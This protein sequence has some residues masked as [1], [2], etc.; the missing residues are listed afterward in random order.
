[1]IWL[2][3]LALSSL[4]IFG[5]MA[6][7]R[8]LILLVGITIGLW[9][10][11]TPAPLTLAP[12]FTDHMVLQQTETVPVWGTAEP[13]ATVSI[14]G[15]WGKSVE[16][17]TDAQGKWI[18]MLETP[19]FG[20]P[21]EL[22]IE[23]AQQQ[24]LLKDVMIGEVWLASGQ[25]NMQWTLGNRINN[26]EEEI[27]NAN[28][29]AI[30]MFSVPRDLSGTKIEN[31]QWQVA[32]SESIKTFSAVGYF[33]ARE[34]HQAL[35]VPVGIIN[36]SWGGTRVEAWMRLEELAKHQMTREAVEELLALGGYEKLKSVNL[37]YN[38]SIKNRN[39]A[40]LGKAAVLLPQ[41]NDTLGFQNLDLKDN[42]FAQVDLNTE[43]WTGIHLKNAID[44]TSG[45]MIL[46]F[47]SL[48]NNN[49]WGDDG[50]VWYRKKFEFSPQNSA[51]YELVYEGGVDDWNQTFLNGVLIGQ[52][53]NCCSEVRYS[54]PQNLL[55]EGENTLA[56]RVIDTGGGGGFRGNIYLENNGQQNVI[57]EGIWHFKQQAFHING[58]LYQHTYTNAELLQNE[59]FLDKNL[60]YGITLN[61]PNAFGI[62]NEKMILPIVPYAIKGALW[63]QGESNVNNYQDYQELFSSMIEDWR[64]QWNGLAFPFYYVQIA[65]YKYTPEQSSQ[66]LRDAQRKSLEVAK[67]GMVVTLDIGEEEDIHPA[68]KQD[69]GARLARFALHHDYDQQALVPSGPLYKKHEVSSSGVRVYFD[70]TENGLL[71]K[72][73]LNGFEIGDAEGNFYPAK[74][75]IEQQ[76][77]VLSNAKVK[78]PK[79]V[80]Y[81]WK[82]YFE[83]SLFN[84]EGLPASSFNTY[85]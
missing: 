85:K 69:V 18:A 41:P 43:E 47:E 32:Q 2:I 36:S 60:S 28:F 20:G 3:L 5:I 33:F 1:L 24:F 16:A 19:A 59:G 8:S 70:Y 77:I 74:A 40:F 73:T 71:Q 25:S 30:R 39:A 9:A 55:Q 10:C 42:G 45:Q 26:Q 38:D 61:N 68:N 6:S 76:H 17:K 23:S 57:E 65:P 56:V 62:L 27:A 13:G 11:S 81:G 48:F 67:T 78:Q 15:S 29:D 35:G 14:K 63:Y 7:I 21:H 72:G 54:I 51:A 84:Q 50:V 31:V 12:L 75:T 34:I 49:K 82:N 52:S 58:Y 46:P 83:A 44:I 4:K 37:R 64:Q 66:A 53:W 79:H 80:R 22:Q